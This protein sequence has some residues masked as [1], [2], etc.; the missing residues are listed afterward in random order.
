MYRFLIFWYLLAAVLAGPPASQ[1]MT[2]TSRNLA[3]NVTPPA[4]LTNQTIESVQLSGSSVQFAESGPYYL[5]TLTTNLGPQT[6]TFNN[7]S[8]ASYQLVASGG[9]CSGGDTTHF[10]ISG[11]GIYTTTLA[12]GTY[13]LCIT[14]SATGVT[15][16]TATF[17]GITEGHKIDAAAGY[18]A[19]NGGGNGSSSSPWQASCIQA[20]VDAAVNG[21]TVFLAAGNWALHTGGVGDT[22]VTITASINL[23][24]A[25]SG[26]TFNVYGQPNYS[27]TAA[28]NLCPSTSITCV[29]TTGTNNTSGQG[30]FI[31]FVGTS[32]FSGTACTNVAASHIYIDGSAATAGGGQYGTLNFLNCPGPIAV[33]D[34][35]VLNFHTNSIASESQF[36]TD[37]ISNLTVQNSV[38]T[39]PVDSSNP[40]FYAGNEIFS[41][42]GGNTALIKNNVFYQASLN[43]IVVD[44][45]IYTGNVNVMDYDG[46][47]RV[48]IAPAFGIAGCGLG[49]L[50][51]YDGGTTGT[52]HFLATNNYFYAVGESFGTGGGVNDPGTGGGVSDLNW[53]GNW[54]VAN[55]GSIAGCVWHVFSNC[56]TGQVGSADGMQ[57]NG[58]GGA[59]GN[60]T[61]DLSGTCFNITNNSILATT[62]AILDATG[63]G[64][65]SPSAPN[66]DHNNTTV[67]FNAHQN[68]LSSAGNR[69]L[70]DSGT[71]NP[72]VTG[73]YCAGG[74]TF[75]QT[76]LTSCAT[77]GFTTPPTVSFTLGLLEQRGG[78]YDVPFTVTNFTA[79]YGAVQWLASTSFTTPSPTDSRWAYVPPVYLSGV[80]HG[81]TVYLWVMDSANHISTPGSTLIP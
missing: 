58:T 6:P 12:A 56:P 11:D 10:Q 62:N 60:C 57:V 23:V 77:S 41:I 47:A 64:I 72:S 68:Y 8:G 16:Y 51:I 53:T 14:A 3:I 37:Q 20:A 71:I 59:S 17:A 67:N 74:S 29:A 35:R 25:A 4:N 75:T 22:P 21:D 49:R 5:G 55:V 50:C 18:C 32:E 36:A 79:Q 48:G 45:V 70:S 54:I 39:V 19:N 15:P 38:F 63:N 65:T 78:T 69:Y 27:N 9:S 76:N 2:S 81:Q 73:N 52:Y 26:N 66:P 40:S 46:V 13:T 80:T 30:G 28:T 24:G 43:P 1:A 7:L 44:S 61:I 34:I 33:S 31:Q 42:G